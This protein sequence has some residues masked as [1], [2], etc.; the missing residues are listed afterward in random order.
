MQTILILEDEYVRVQRFMDALKDF[1]FLIIVTKK[2]KEACE[3]FEKCKP[4]FVFL[5]HDLDD[6][7]DD[8]KH[9]NTGMAVAKFIAKSE[10]KPKYVLIHTMNVPASERMEKELLDKK[11]NL[12]AIPFCCISFENLG[13]FLNT[14]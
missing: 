14:F 3:L 10:H 12:D 4:E 2:A 8:P 13:I 5:D 7:F 9:R 1:N 11:I 6:S